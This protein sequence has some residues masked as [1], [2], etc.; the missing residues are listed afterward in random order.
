[1]LLTCS[2]VLTYAP[3]IGVYA[4]AIRV[5]TAGSSSSSSSYEA[6][7]LGSSSSSD[8][9]ISADSDSQLVQLLGK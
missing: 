4:D 3:K 6:I 1:M 7:L 2:Q 9:E 5:N 8:E